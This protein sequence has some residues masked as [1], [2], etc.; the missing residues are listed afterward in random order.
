[1]TE[2]RQN[3]WRKKRNIKITTEELFEYYVNEF[4]NLFKHKLFWIG[5]LPACMLYN[6]KVPGLDSNIINYNRIIRD[7]LKDHFIDMS[8][9]PESGFMSDFHHPNSEG[10]LFIYNK[11][12]THLNMFN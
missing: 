3:N 8:D 9:F 10:H 4:S 1:M 7:I 12:I 2:K 6:L 11:I 5:I